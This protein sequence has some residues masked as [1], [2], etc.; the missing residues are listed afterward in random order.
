MSISSPL[1]QQINHSI[2][3]DL[4]E[5]GWSH[6]R[7]FLSPELTLALAAQCRANAAAGNLI[8]AGVGRGTERTVQQGIRGDHIQWLEAGQSD[9]TDQFLQIIEQL[10]CR[11]NQELYLGLEEVECHFAL[12]PPGAFYQKHVDRFHD[13]DHRVVSMVIYL[14]QDWLPEHGGALRLYPEGEPERDILPLGASLVL[15]LSAALP[16]EVLAATR[17]R[18]SLTGWFRRR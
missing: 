11:L 13:D 8:A 9:P 17:E 14:N 18:L 6:Q 4:A 1:M 10:R 15:F 2:I 7:D 12:Y 3:D 16:H 5:H